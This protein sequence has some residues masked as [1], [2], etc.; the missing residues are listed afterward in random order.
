MYACSS[1]EQSTSLRS[2]GSQVRVL[3][4]VPASS[5]FGEMAELVEGALLLRGYGVKSLIE[6]SN[7]SFSATF[8]PRLRASGRSSSGPLA[9]LV[10]Q[11][12][13]NFLVLGSSPRRPT[14]I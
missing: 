3:S 2:L 14:K 11:E 5:F 8:A 6:G 7:P 1:V 13:L 4:G 9:Q 10:E 12:A